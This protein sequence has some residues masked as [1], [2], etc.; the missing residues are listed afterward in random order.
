MPTALAPG[1]SPQGCCLQCRLHFACN[2]RRLRAQGPRWAGSV[3]AES[4][5]R[6]RQKSTD[7]PG[8]F[9]AWQ[10]WTLGCELP[11]GIEL[12]RAA[13]CGHGSPGACAR[14][15]GQA[16][17]GA[18]VQVFALRGTMPPAGWCRAGTG[19][20][21]PEG[22]LRLWVRWG[23]NPVRGCCSSCCRIFLAS[24]EAPFPGGRA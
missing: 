3:R 7:S 19:P 23:W 18:W 17:P 14:K 22:P 5:L 9:P 1:G 6:T 10:Q 24:P 15:S 2:R 4:T 21:G 20:C 12:G 13:S 11:A 8:R 16:C